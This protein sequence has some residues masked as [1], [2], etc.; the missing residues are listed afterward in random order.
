[1][2]LAASLGYG[3]PT[4]VDLYGAYPKVKKENV[5]IIGAR[6]LDEGEKTLFEMKVL[7]YFQ[8]TRLI[9]WV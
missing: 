6:A 5:V 2:S 7:K 8:C 3:H 9:V 4:L 1:M